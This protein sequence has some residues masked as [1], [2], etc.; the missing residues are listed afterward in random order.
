MVRFS[1]REL[2][3]AFGLALQCILVALLASVG[4]LGLAMSALGLL[5]TVVGILLLSV[6]ATVVRR[7]S[8]SQAQVRDLLKSVGTLSKEVSKI[9]SEMRG[10]R[11]AQQMTAQTSGATLECVQQATRNFA[12][13]LTGIEK[14]DVQPE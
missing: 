13:Q 6:R 10:I 1:K 12:E 8:P 14:P 7:S 3:A 4:S 5:V 11:I 9:Q 2:L